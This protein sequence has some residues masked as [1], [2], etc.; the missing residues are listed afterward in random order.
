MKGLMADLI[1]VQKRIEAKLSEA[2]QE[3]QRL[4]TADINSS[5]AVRAT[6]KELKLRELKRKVDEVINNAEEFFPYVVL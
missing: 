2:S 4:A 6:D 3:A 5:D 1:K